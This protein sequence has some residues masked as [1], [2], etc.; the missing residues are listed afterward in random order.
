VFGSIMWMIYEN[1]RIVEDERI[2]NERRLKQKI[3]E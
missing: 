2:G 3:I 1:K